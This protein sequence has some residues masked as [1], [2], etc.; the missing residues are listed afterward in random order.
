MERF[1]RKLIELVDN[2]PLVVCDNTLC[3]YEVPTEVNKVYSREHLVE[4]AKYLDKPCPLCG[5]NLLTYEDLKT[6]IS[7]YKT[8]TWLNKYFSW[9][10]WFTSNKTWAKRVTMRAHVHN[11]LKIDRKN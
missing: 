2:G 11:G 5:E 10:T 4:L 6:Y 9:I 8:I 7:T 1:K 3:D